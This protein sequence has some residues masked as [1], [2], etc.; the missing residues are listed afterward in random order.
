[1]DGWMRRRRHTLLLLLLCAVAV[2]LLLLRAGM[3]WSNERK[4]FKATPLKC[5][6]ELIKRLEMGR[7]D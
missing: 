6:F 7:Q 2:G 5:P 3:L 4:A 1:M